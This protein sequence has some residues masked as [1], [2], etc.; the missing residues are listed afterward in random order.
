ME[1][2]SY[3]RLPKILKINRIEKSKLKVSV[4]FSD[5]EDRILDFNKIF[6]KNWKVTKNDP[7]YVLL[8]PNEF[9]KVKLEHHTLSWHNVGLF[10]TGKNNEKIKVPFDVGADTLY[11]LSQPDEKLSF[12]VGELVKRARLSAKLSQEKVAELSGTSRTYITKL[13]NN[14]ESD[15]QLMTLKKIVEAG[16]NKH[17]SINIE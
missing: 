6:K 7:E 13:E 12:S 14:S 16:L 5:G 4:L 9:A 8:S 1:K 15:I 10:M 17:L 3:K 2:T 11:E